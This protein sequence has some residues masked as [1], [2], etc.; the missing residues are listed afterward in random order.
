MA[1]KLNN[2]LDLYMQLFDL[3][4]NKANLKSIKFDI[5]LVDGEEVYLRYETDARTV[6]L[7][8]GSRKVNASKKLLVTL[9]NVVINS[10]PK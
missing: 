7:N 1:K 5:G 6:S 10:I 9:S 8:I 3:L 4:C 2:E